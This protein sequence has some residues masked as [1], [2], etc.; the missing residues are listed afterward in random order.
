MAEKSKQSAGI[1][2]V[3]LATA[4]VF[5]MSFAFLMYRLER[6]AP[7]DTDER[8]HVQWRKSYLR[9]PKAR[10]AM[11]ELIARRT[12]PKPAEPQEPAYDFYRVLPEFNVYVSP[13]VDTSRPHVAPARL[14]RAAQ[15]ASRQTEPTMITTAA[16]QTQP[17]AT[18]QPVIIQQQP[19]ITYAQPVP[20]ATLVQ[21]GQV[22]SPQT[23]AAATT[24]DPFADKPGA[25]L[26]VGAFR[27]RDDASRRRAEVALLGLRAHIEPAVIHGSTVFRVKLGPFADL[28]ARTDATTRLHSAG[29]DTLIKSH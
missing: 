24:I 6:S 5:L 2:M 25:W 4:S 14:R 15:P 29:I 19:V 18:Q 3:G 9:P 8:T 1:Q 23:P 22:S 28:T 20:R 16:A 26:Q 12:E 7:V 10:D 27:Q 11:D 17:Q 21:A 13:N